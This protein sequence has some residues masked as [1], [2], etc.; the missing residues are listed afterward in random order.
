[1][2]IAESTRRHAK[3]LRASGYIQIDSQ[4]LRERVSALGY[5][6]TKSMLTSYTRTEAEF[7]H[8]ERTMHYTD[9]R[10]KASYL[11][12]SACR[13]KRAKLREYTRNRFVFEAG[14]IWD[15]WPLREL[16]ERK[17]ELFPSLLLATL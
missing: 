11:S 7:P 16:E 17:P 2:T 10:I 3:L 15:L 8:R 4:E 6:I 9:Q 12:P 1:M 5:R 14:Y 13:T